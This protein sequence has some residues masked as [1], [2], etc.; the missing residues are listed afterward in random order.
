[1]NNTITRYLT[2]LVAVPLLIS[3]IQFSP[4][5]CFNIVISA[6]LLIALYEW[7]V[8]L[9][10]SNMHIPRL[11][12]MI[13]GVISL[14]ALHLFA[15][16]EKSSIIYAAAMIVVIGIC[17]YNILSKQRDLGT[18]SVS[19]SS[20][21]TSIFVTCWGG[22]ALILIREISFAADNR[23]LIYLLLSIVWLGDAGAMHAAGWPARGFPGSC[24]WW[25]SCGFGSGGLHKYMN[26]ATM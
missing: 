13:L 2:A 19:M 11:Y 25:E 1:M 4:G 18:V 12:C 6:A 7:L 22:G 16:A 20:I 14:G 26:H 17:G 10:K 8:L 21:F 15:H 23:Y 9:D 24:C 5:W 3:L